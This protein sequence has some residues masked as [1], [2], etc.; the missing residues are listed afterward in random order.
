MPS[1]T[2]YMQNTLKLVQIPPP[3]LEQRRRRMAAFAP[4]GQRTR[5]SMPSSLN[6]GSPV[7]YRMRL[8]LTPEQ[9]EEAALLLSL[10]KTHSFCRG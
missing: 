8:P 5:Y 9:A 7:G 10:S 3:P 6:S 2:E 4:P 1:W